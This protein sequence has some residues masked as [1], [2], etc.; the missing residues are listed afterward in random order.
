M[1]A[2]IMDAKSKTPSERARKRVWIDLD[3]SPHVPFFR[4]IIRELEARGC[5]VIVTGRDC[6]ETVQLLDLYGI[7]YKRIGRHYG[8]NKIKKVLGLF[9]RSFQVYRYIR[10]QKVDIA[11]SHGSRS[12]AQVATLLNIPLVTLFDYEWTKGVPFIRAKVRKMLVPDAIPFEAVSAKRID[13]EAV[14]RYHGIKEDVYLCGFE[15]NE[16]SLHS[17]G[18]DQDKVIVTF[19]PPASHAHYHNPRSDRIC[20]VLLRR[21]AEDPNTQTVFLARTAEQRRLALEIFAPAP[22]RLVVPDGVVGGLDLLWASD[23]AISGGGTMVREAA[24]LGVPAY[25]IFCG[26]KGAV[27]LY[28]EKEGKLTFVRDV[29]DVSMISFTKR[30]RDASSIRRNDIVAEIVDEIL[31]V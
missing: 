17:L 23:V 13:R 30:Q 14:R 28:L 19:R 3:N 26:Q 31:S 18:L 9:V 4:P 24:G 7:P 20:E 29:A 25:S 1:R 12:Q 27:D 5:E 16:D 11:V 6:F 21:L 2:R 8:K 10:D 22:K 15:P